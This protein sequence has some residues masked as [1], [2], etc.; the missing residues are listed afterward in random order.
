MPARRSEGMPWWPLVDGRKPWRREKSIWHDAGMSTAGVAQLVALG[1]DANDPSRLAGF[2]AEALGWSVGDEAGGEVPVV[3][4]D[5]T[6]FQ[7]VFRSAQVQ[8]AGRN[9]IHLDLTTVSLD[10]QQR[11]VAT[12]LELGGRHVDVG[13]RS[14]EGH[15]VLSDPEGNEFC[16]IE[17]GNRFLAGCGRLGAINCDGTRRVGYFWSQTLGWPLVWDQDEETAIR[18][19]DGT[20]PL[21]TWSGPPLIPKFGMNRLRLDLAPAADDDD[22]ADADDRPAGDRRADVDRDPT[23]DRLVSLGATVVDDHGGDTGCV[24]M[25]DPDDNEFCVLTAPIADR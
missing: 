23:V 14:D 25:A 21:I 3:P 1:F 24:V 19:P 6:R 8:K 17:P 5:G 7:L 9:R 15:V 11:L 18:A 22:R 20:G 13:Q 16:V 2:W 10:D 4:T 12:L